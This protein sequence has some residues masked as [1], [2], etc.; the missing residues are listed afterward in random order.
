MSPTGN[1]HEQPIVNR[2]SWVF[3]LAQR[4]SAEFCSPE[5]FLARERYLALHPTAI[6]VLKCLDGRINIP[7]ATGERRLTKFEFVDLL[8]KKAATVLQFD[9]SHCGGI[10]EAKK[11]ASMAVASIINAALLPWLD[12]L[13][14]EQNETPSN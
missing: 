2:I 12:K 14:P 1:I 7:V 3:D 4:Y 13:S 11:I 10:L 6:A 8:E 9:V 5:A